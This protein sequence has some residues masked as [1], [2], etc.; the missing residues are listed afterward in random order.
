ME[1]HVKDFE[2][3][4]LYQAVCIESSVKRIRGDGK[5]HVLAVDACLKC[6]PLVLE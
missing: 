6:S 5:D 1:H 2:C 3:D 4:G